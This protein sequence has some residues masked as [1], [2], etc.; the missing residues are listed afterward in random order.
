MIRITVLFMVPLLLMVAALPVSADQLTAQE[1]FEGMVYYE[2][3]QLES[4]PDTTDYHCTVIQTISRPGIRVTESI[5]KDL[6]FMVPVFQLHMIDEVPAYYF[7]SDA[8]I[9]TL[10]SMD[11]ERLRD[12][13]VGEIEC[14]VI[15]ATPRDLAFARFNTTYYVAMD[16]FRHVYTEKYGSNNQ[17]DLTITKLDYTYGTEG[18]FTLVQNILAET[19]DP[20]GNVLFAVEAVYSDYEFNVGLDLEFFISAF[21]GESHPNPVWN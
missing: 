14:Y 21:E 13:T 18:P 6:Y 5:A 19:K 4:Q 16:N 10:E 9:I 1:I 2:N 3:D 17:Y 20:E 7:D 11:I 15:K 8:I 12:A